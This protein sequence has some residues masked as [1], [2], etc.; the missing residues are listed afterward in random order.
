MRAQVPYSGALTR[1]DG[2]VKVVPVPEQDF[3]ERVRNSTL[4]AEYATAIDRESAREQIGKALDS[5]AGR[6][7]QREL[8]RG[9][10]GVLGI[11][12]GTRRRRSGW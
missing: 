3:T 2:T 7:L 12:S 4:S 10:F 5:P 9:L 6:T 8:V 1:G 11:R